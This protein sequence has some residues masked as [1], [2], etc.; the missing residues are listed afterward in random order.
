MNLPSQGFQLIG[1]QRARVATFALFF[2][3]VQ[4]VL[5]PRPCLCESTCGSPSRPSG[6]KK[7]TSPFTGK[8]TRA[9]PARAVPAR[10]FDWYVVDSSSGGGL[11][12]LTLE[13]DWPGG[14]GLRAKLVL[15]PFTITYY[16]ILGNRERTSALAIRVWGHA[17]AGTFE[18]PPGT[19]LPHEKRTAFTKSPPKRAVIAIIKADNCP[20]RLAI[21]LLVPGQQHLLLHWPLRL[22]FWIRVWLP[23]GNER[24]IF[25]AK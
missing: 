10:S 24:V 2:S 13:G 8:Q 6:T 17:G 16:D 1:R 22:P 18:R 12:L 19:F 3:F 25:Y 11:H 20:G 9:A 4:L 14:G 5:S 15:V 7:P 23:F 21:I